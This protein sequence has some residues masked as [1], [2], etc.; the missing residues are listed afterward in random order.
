[1]IIPDDIT[2]ETVTESDITA[3]PPAKL[4]KFWLLGVLVATCIV[5]L[6]GIPGNIVTILALLKSPSPR[7]GTDYLVMNLALSDLLSCLVT[8]PYVII[9]Y[10]D[11]GL[12]VAQR[13]R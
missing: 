8:Q 6:L 4:V 5:G 12:Q 7:K 1:M 3:A 2:M 11:W 10:T 9:H 13:H